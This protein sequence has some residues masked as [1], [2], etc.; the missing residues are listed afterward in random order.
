MF[1]TL[2]I[3]ITIISSGDNEGHNHPRPRIVAASALTGHKLIKDDR[4]VTP[5]IYSTEIAR[6][7]K[8]TEPEKL[9]LGKKW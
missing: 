9:I 3:Q 6:S 8:I 5:L 2:R 7:Y 4:V 1:L